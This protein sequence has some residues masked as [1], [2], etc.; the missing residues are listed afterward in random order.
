LAKQNVAKMIIALRMPDYGKL[1]AEMLKALDDAN[2]AN[3]HYL[4]S[5]RHS[6]NNYVKSRGRR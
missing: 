5:A 6:Y 3:P 1:L 4:G 2:R